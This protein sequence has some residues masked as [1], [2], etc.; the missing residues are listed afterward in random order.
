[1]TDSKG[2]QAIA[3]FTIHAAAEKGLA[4]NSITAY[5][6]DL[7]LLH[8]WARREKIAA[9]D[10]VRDADLRRFLLVISQDLAARSRARLVS[11]LRSFYRF[12]MADKLAARD[13]TATIVAPRLGRKLPIVL[14]VPQTERLLAAPQGDTPVILRDRCILELLYGCGLRVSEV[15]GLNVD[16]LDSSSG[17][18]RV[19]G[20]GSKQRLV[21]VGD[22]ALRA[23]DGYIECGRPSLRDQRMTP[24]LLLNQRGGR[25]SR[26]SV[27]QILKR[28]ATVADLGQEVTP[29]TLRHTFAT[30]L[31]EG[32]ADLRAV[33]ELLG[34]ADISTT[35]IYTH[36]DRAFLM[37]AYRAAHPRARGRNS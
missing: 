23:T 1:M 16:D 18:L 33:Q 31:L 4:L 30:H 24:A 34:H 15:C 20:K 28:Y 6:H 13:P 37:E 22:P 27:W 17:T 32:G 5:R 10:R 12:L 8:G 25:L 3:A 9:P 35:E 36:I 2:E 19:R 11:T 21:P 26:V 7:E 14:T 29:H